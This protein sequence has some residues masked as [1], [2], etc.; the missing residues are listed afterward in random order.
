L[1]QSGYE[2]NLVFQVRAV[3]LPA[4]ECQYRFAPPRRWTFD[5]AWPD[6][7]IAC[8]VEGG[9]WIRGGGRHNRASSFEKDAE[10]YNEAGLLGWAVLRVT[11]GQVKTG[12]A[13]TLLERALGGPRPPEGVTPK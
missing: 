9:I 8:E 7:R 12:V 13:L 6:R 1:S 11:T 5:L 10:K 2:R 4:P 3:K